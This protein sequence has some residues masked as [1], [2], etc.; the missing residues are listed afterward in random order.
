MK[1]QKRSFY[2]NNAAKTKATIITTHNI[3][4]QTETSTTKVL[5]YDRQ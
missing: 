4:L 3:Q 1:R 5:L 2:E